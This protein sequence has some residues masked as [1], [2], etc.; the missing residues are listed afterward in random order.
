VAG[1]VAPVPLSPL[2]ELP[3]AL[4]SGA[5]IG[6]V[7]LD[8]GVVVVLLLDAGGVDVEDGVDGVVVAPVS[9]TFLP[10]APSA[11]KAARA[12]AVKAAGLNLDASMSISLY[13]NIKPIKDDP[14]RSID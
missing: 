3:A 2:D 9:S 4:A 5:G 13:K 6:L 14:K 7:E 8:E 10:Q 11:S 12:M 1:D